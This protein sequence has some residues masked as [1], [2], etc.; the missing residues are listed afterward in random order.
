M[1]LGL[2]DPFRGP[3]EV[4]DS[5]GGGGGFI[6]LVLAIIVIVIGFGVVLSL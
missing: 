4:F 1:T 6:I 3:E 5:N 2:P